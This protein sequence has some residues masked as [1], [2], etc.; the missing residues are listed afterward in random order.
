M[1]ALLNCPPAVFL[2]F[3]FSVLS[4]AQAMDI[5]P[6]PEIVSK[7]YVQRGLER[8]SAFTVETAGNKKAIEQGLS[9]SAPI[10]DDCG[11]IFVLDETNEQF[12]WMK[13]MGFGLDILFFDKDRRL[14]EIL[15][16]LQP[17]DECAKYKAPANT[18]YALEIKAGRANALGIKTGDIFVFAKE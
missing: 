10:P 11:M 6:A 16:N 17:C 8:I 3:L 18:A 4:S 14:I 2:I 15:P 7:I 5:N 1:A 9:K 12:F 13:G